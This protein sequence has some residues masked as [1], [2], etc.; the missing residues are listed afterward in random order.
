MLMSLHRRRA[1]T[2]CPQ[3]KGIGIVDEDDVT[4]P[5]FCGECDGAGK[6]EERGEA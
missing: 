1:M 4:Q 2:D 6:V 3:C 5:L